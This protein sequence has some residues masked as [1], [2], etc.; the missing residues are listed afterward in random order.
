[1]EDRPLTILMIKEG[2]ALITI[3]GELA[4][5]RLTLLKEDIEKAS[6]FIRNESARSLHPISVLIDLRA[7]SATYEPEAMVLL[8]DFAKEDQ[9]YVRKT[10]CFGAQAK[11]K[12]AGEII[13]ALSNRKNISFADTREE[14]LAALEQ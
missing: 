13:T 8:A 2:I 4:G 11:I 9:P 6:T 14:A 3:Q 1:M 5:D 7:L 12:F 10:V